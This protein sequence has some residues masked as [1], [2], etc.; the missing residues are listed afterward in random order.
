MKTNPKKK[1]EKLREE[2]AFLKWQNDLYKKMYS[3]EMIALRELNARNLA[4]FQAGAYDLIKIPEE[5]DYLNE[6]KV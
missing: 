2:N 5:L 4:Y 1:I 6:K 3:P